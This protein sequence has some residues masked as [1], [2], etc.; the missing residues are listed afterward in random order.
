MTVLVVGIILIALLLGVSLLQWMLRR[1]QAAHERRLPHVA[2][3]EALVLDSG[4]FPSG[5]HVDYRGPL[6]NERLAYQSGDENAALDELDEVGR[7]I[8]YRQAFR[9][10]RSYGELIDVPLNL[11]VRS[12]RQQRM[13]TVDLSLFEDAEG[14][15]E[16]VGEAPP[17]ADGSIRVSDVGTHELDFAE[18]VRQWSRL[19]GEEELQRKVEVRW[20]SGRLGCVVA[21][22]S[23]PPGGIEAA[24]VCAI[25]KRIQDRVGGSALASNGAAA[26]A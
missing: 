10:P 8:G 23:E 7:V 25:A 19:Q 14:A 9:D 16:F 11:T 17:A 6:T 12:S 15:S 13:L 24:E 3:L 2:E 1:R 21:G 20:R 26:D 5:Y 18:S 4:E 22:D